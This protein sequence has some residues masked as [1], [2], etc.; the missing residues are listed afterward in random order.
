MS[1][2]KIV[3]LD[4]STLSPE[5]VL[6]AP[7]F[8]ADFESFDK[9]PPEAVAERIT[10]ADI[11]ITNKVPV[12]AAA[13]AGAKRLKM[14]AI[15]A[16]GYDIVDTKACAEAGITVSNIR[17]YAKNTVPEHTFALI[18]ALQ[19]SL[20]PYRRSVIAGRWEEAASFSYF[21]Y[22]IAD[23]AGKR[24]GIIGSGALGQSVAAIARGFGMDIVFSGHKGAEHIGSLYTPF[25][26]VLRTSDIITLHCP[27]TPSTRNMISDA[28]F[29]QM[30]Q[31][32]LL[33]NTAR[34]GLV[35][36]DALERA[37]EAGLIRGAGF[38]VATAEPPG[39]D[40]IIHRIAR[41]DNV[42][43]TPHV[44][45]AS[46]EAIQA[47]ADQLMDNIDAFAAGKPRNVVV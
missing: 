15:S 16:T 30:G 27:L 28:E 25:E 24:L 2:M 8:D 9:T 26:T 7:G 43:V 18:L 12:R 21:D 38:D 36:E 22:P 4:R 37:L 42:I 31:T 39:A 46:R 14:I 45:W 40:H 6:R 41:R 35:D 11:V 47:L 5:T 20:I 32:P 23:L 19:R 17:G 29:A 3:F 10:D 34:G 33:I 13:I 44:A 1:R